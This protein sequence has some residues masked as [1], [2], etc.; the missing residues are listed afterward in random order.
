MYTYIKA[1]L[2][3]LLIAA[4]II[5]LPMACN[6]SNPQLLEEMI[7]FHDEAHVRGIDVTFSKLGIIRYSTYHTMV[8]NDNYDGLEEL[9]GVC[10][11][12]HELISG[13]NESLDKYVIYLNP[14]LEHE[15]VLRKIVLFHELAHCELS[16]DHQG[17]EGTLLNEYITHKT[18]AA[19][20]EDFSHLL[21]LLFNRYK[22]K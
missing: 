18:I 16:M 1:I 10:I 15:E 20:I 8:V 22:S 7:E 19:A 4:L 13:L 14:Y 11:K 9:L 2:K 17:P 12:P 6:A 5:Y 3:G 21:D